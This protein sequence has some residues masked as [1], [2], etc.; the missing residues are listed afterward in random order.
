[1]RSLRIYAI[2]EKLR[3]NDA[4][5]DLNLK[6]AQRLDLVSAGFLGLLH[7]NRAGTPDPG[8]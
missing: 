2:T 3:L 1:M 7:L 8:I 6:A 5:F 4:S